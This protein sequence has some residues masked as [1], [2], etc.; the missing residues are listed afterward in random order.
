LEKRSQSRI[1]LNKIVRTEDR[2]KL[3]IRMARRSCIYRNPVAFLFNLRD[4][5]LRILSLLL[6]DDQIVYYLLQLILFLPDCTVAE[7]DI[8]YR[9]FVRLVRI[10][11]I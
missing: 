10:Q 8:L 3:R 5:F 11:S 9:I 4:V 6:I 7:T 1:F 2:S